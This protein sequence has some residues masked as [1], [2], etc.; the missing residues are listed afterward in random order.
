M[1]ATNAVCLF[2]LKMLLKKENKSFRSIQFTPFDTH[3]TYGNLTGFLKKKSGKGS[4]A[5]FLRN[6]CVFILLLIIFIVP[7]IIFNEFINQKIPILLNTKIT[8][9]LPDWAKVIMIIMLPLAQALI[10]FPWFYGYMYPR[11]ETHFVENRGNR[12]TA[13]SIKALLI[14][15]AFFVLQAAL[16]PLI[17]NPYF[18][19]WR[20]VSMFPLLLFI[21]IILRLVPRFMPGANVMHALMAV[22]VALQYWRL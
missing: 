21:G 2:I 10:E 9:I 12:R 3:L 20:A 14:V 15:L 18:I 11:L 22:S 13:A 4:I 19:L 6:A 1:I 7:A 5:G 8:G 16:I 17:L